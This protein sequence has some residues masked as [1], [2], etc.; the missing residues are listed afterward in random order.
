M[1]LCKCG[2]VGRGWA[3]GRCVAVWPLW[4]VRPT[5]VCQ[6]RVARSANG[7]IVL[8]LPTRFVAS[9]DNEWIT[10]LELGTLRGTVRQGGGHELGVTG[11]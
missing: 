8:P 5:P 2:G 3:R 11:V 1:L 4:M 10:I 7:T 6:L 9:A